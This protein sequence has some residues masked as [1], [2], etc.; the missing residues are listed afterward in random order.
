MD[1]LKYCNLSYDIV[2]VCYK[3]NKHLKNKHEKCKYFV[4]LYKKCIQKNISK[5][6]I[7]YI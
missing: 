3:D 7:I 5:N 4:D 1:K 2:Q 6:N